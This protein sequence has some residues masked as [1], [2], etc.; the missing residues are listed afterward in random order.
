[1]S[2]RALR[3]EAEKFDAPVGP[4]Y[5]CMG[6]WAGMYECVGVWV[7]RHAGGP[8]RRLY[9]FIA[10]IQVY[11]YT[12]WGMCVCVFVWAYVFCVLYERMGAR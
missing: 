2:T 12:V 8:E 9:R 10:Y 4:V 5:G 6:L 7:Y 1:M 3:K 11:G